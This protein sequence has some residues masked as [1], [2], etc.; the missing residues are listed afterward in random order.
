MEYLKR[1]FE[2]CDYTPQ[3]IENIYKEQK[4]SV[5]KRDAYVDKELQIFVQEFF[6]TI[7]PKSE[8]DIRPKDAE[9]YEFWINKFED[10]IENETGLK[11]K[12]KRVE[13]V[14]RRDLGKILTETKLSKELLAEISASPDSQTNFFALLKDMFTLFKDILFFREVSKRVLGMYDL[15]ATEAKIDY[16]AIYIFE[17][18]IKE[19]AKRC[20]IESFSLGKIVTIH[21]DI[22][23]KQFNTFPHLEKIREELTKCLYYLDQIKYE[24]PKKEYQRLKVRVRDALEALLSVCE[25]HAEYYT[26]KIGKKVIYGFEEIEKRL[27]GNRRNTNPLVKRKIEKLI[28]RYKAGKAFIEKVIPSLGNE[29][30]EQEMLPVSM[31]EIKSPSLYIKRYV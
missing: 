1:V 3:N 29:I 6:K 2:G 20:G 21:E 27:R 12:V 13:V 14:D 7:V 8:F 9:K 26:E 23:S 11:G 28:E 15:I 18:N 25:G 31:E 30:F 22:H 5:E 10:I 4:K 16:D 24:L 19:R 17:Q